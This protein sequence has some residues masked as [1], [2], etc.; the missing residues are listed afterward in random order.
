MGLC[1]LY[2]WICLIVLLLCVLL[3]VLGGL[4]MVWGGGG[5]LGNGTEAPGA[6]GSLQN[7][8][9]DSRQSGGTPVCVLQHGTITKQLADRLKELDG[10]KLDVAYLYHMC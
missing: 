3:S 4:G 2:V 9:S 10:L 7:R 5:D 6:G 1:V 8:P